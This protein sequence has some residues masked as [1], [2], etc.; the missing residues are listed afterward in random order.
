MTV[1]T[2]LTWSEMTTTPDPMDPTLATSSRPEDAISATPCHESSTG[3]PTWSNET[4]PNGRK[5][6]E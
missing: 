6:S 3:L 2:I 5:K 4:P 1:M